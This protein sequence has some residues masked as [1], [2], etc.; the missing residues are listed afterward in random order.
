M[1]S[2]KSVVAEFW[3]SKQR[4]ANRLHEISYR[5]CFKPQLPNYFI[6]RLTKPKEIVYDPF[7][8]RG[9]TLLEAAL[10]NRI[11]YGSDINPLS[12]VLI[13]PRLN[14]PTIEDVEK[15]LKAIPWLEKCELREDLL[16]FYHPETLQEIC[17]LRS[18][19][20]EK[21]GEKKGLDPIDEWIRMTAVNRLTGHSP[22]FFSVYTLPPNQAV[23]VQSQRKINEKRKQIPP[24]RVVP[25]LIAKKSRQLLKGLTPKHREILAQTAKKHLAL[26]GS[27]DST[28]EIM[29]ESVSLVVT[30]PPFL[31]VVNY[32][33]DNWLRGWFIGVDSSKIPFTT[34]PDEATW[35][36]A[37]EKVFRELHRV[38]KPEGH[39]AFEVGEVQKGSLKLEELVV[40]CGRSAGLF[41]REILINQQKFTKTSQCWGISNNE[42]GTNSN[43]I[44]LFQ[45]SPAPQLKFFF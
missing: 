42:E 35:C 8:G 37:M 15:R 39:V 6:Q 38:L 44:V 7:M 12:K 1:D 5:A 43:R 34:P 32:A 45:K 17:A 31:D 16:T 40:P 10:Q 19:F 11:A 29:S 4:D 27:A 23:T 33:V 26:V 21:E 22:G 18:Y 3:T 25:A 9:T 24:R 30:S 2:L 28:P 13:K 20:L 41:A 36:K 14:P